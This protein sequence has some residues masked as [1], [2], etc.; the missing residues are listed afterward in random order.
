MCLEYPDNSYKKLFDEANISYETMETPD[1][2][3]SQKK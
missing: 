3:I 1:L 2:N